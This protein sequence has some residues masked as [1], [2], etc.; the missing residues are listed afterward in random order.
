MIGPSRRGF[1][2]LAG[3]AALAGCARPPAARIRVGYQRSGVL[4]PAKTRGVVARAVRPIALEWIEFPSG[5][6]L[7][8]AMTAGAVDFGS[9]GDAPP[10]FAQA[11]GA[12][13]KYVAVQPVSGES[14]ALLVPPDSPLKDTRGL[15]GK[16][17]A[18]TRGTSAHAFLLK[19]LKSVGLTLSDIRPVFLSPA[20]AAAAFPKRAF[21]AWAVWDPYLA[22]A[23]RDQQARV[24]I[25][26]VG[27]P[28]SDAFYLASDRMVAQ[29][30]SA[31][32]ALLGALRAEAAWG[33][34]HPDDLVRIV[35]AGEGLPSDIVRTSLRRGAFAVEPVTPDV[36]ARQQLSADA[37]AELGVIPPIRV[38]DIAWRGFKPA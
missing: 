32:I 37:F 10:I 4:L 8:E 20:D 11:A 1:L 2:T 31:L 33:N 14:D 35:A 15:R 6:P 5:P 34:A 9:T 18:V 13:L 24:L 27:L 29:A 19:A 38:A 26:G 21:D 36:L 17:V 23:Q 30:P 3:A 28:L 22:L 25:S 12:K 7:L 16:A